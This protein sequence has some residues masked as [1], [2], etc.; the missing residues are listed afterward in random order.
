MNN[1]SHNHIDLG[2]FANRPFRLPSAASNQPVACYGSSYLFAAIKLLLARQPAIPKSDLAAL[3]NEAIVL[4]PAGEE[5]IR[6]TKE[7]E[8]KS[9]NQELLHEC[10]RVRAAIAVDRNGTDRNIQELSE[11]LGVTARFFERIQSTHPWTWFER[12]HFWAL[13]GLSVGAILIGQNTLAVTLQS[14]GQPGFDGPVQAYLFSGLPLLVAAGLKS[15][16]ALLRNP[17]WRLLY[18]YALW[19]VGLLFAATWIHLFAN[20]FPGLAQ[21]TEEIIRNLTQSDAT[22]PTGINNLNFVYISMCA[23]TLLAAAAWMTMHAI[24]DRHTPSI[25]QPNPA[26]VSTQQELD[27]WKHYADQLEQALGNLE[28]KI[29]SIKHAEVRFVESA[30]IYYRK[31]ARLSGGDDPTAGITAPA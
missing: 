23:E 7:S 29:K 25:R 27:R 3:K 22:T 12:L 8:F 26:Y 11:V 1:D 16:G 5:S 15:V 10:L 30:V 20:I 14:S 9:L 13:G 6:K 18:T 28:G 19:L 4:G 21:S 2:H 24:H 31:I 17:K